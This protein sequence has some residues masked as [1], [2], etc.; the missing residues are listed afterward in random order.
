MWPIPVQNK[1]SS[2]GINRAKTLREHKLNLVPLVRTIRCL[3]AFEIKRKICKNVK[4]SSLKLQLIIHL[5]LHLDCIFLIFNTKLTVQ[6]IYNIIYLSIIN[7][8]K[9]YILI[10]CSVQLRYIHANLNNISLIMY[11]DVYV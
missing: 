4:T 7:K 10:S 2:K 1:L 3:L 8:C 9:I 5:Y 11:T 6:N